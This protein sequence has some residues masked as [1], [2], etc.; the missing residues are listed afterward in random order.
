MVNLQLRDINLHKRYLHST[1]HKGD[2]IQFNTETIAQHL[3]KK[4]VLKCVHILKE[5]T[6]VCSNMLRMLITIAIERYKIFSV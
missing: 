6:V 4:S 1:Y 2:N 3:T 5:L